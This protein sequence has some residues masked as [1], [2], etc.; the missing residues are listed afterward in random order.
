MI[1]E[2]QEPRARSAIDE[3]ARSPS[4]VDSAARAR[5]K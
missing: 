2:E 1:S 5:G 4:P 3:R